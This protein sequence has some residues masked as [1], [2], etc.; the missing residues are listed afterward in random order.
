MFSNIVPPEYII[1]RGRFGKMTLVIYDPPTMGAY[2]T[3]DLPYYDK[4]LNKEII[5][6]NMSIV[7]KGLGLIYEN[8]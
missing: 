1:E 5:E 3:I 7:Y 6:T 2:K 8:Y 4:K